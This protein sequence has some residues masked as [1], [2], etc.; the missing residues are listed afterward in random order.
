MP[1]ATLG[2]WTLAW[3]TAGGSDA[4]LPMEPTTPPAS[5]QSDELTPSVLLD[6]IDATARAKQVRMERLRRQLQQLGEASRRVAPAHE[7]PTV[8]ETL[9]SDAQLPEE[10][11]TPEAH[12]VADPP[13]AGDG[14][15][16][17][18]PADIDAPPLESGT[19][20]HAHPEEHG[21][22]ASPP[23]N[24]HAP[25]AAAEAEVLPGAQIDRLAL[26]DSLFATG[27]SDLALQ[28]Y[29]SIELMKL[30]AADRY[31]IEYQIA[32]CHRRLGNKP[33]AEQR[34]RRIAG[35]IDGGWCATHARWWLDAL[36]KKA[37]LERDLEQIKLTLQATEEQLNAK[38]AQ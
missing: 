9:E 34:Y 3:A 14:L 29:D 33:E 25:H 17:P 11:P 22:E 24:P 21:T 30:A 16:V 36:A 1:I 15:A 2:V 8:P 31:W 19:D 37:D 26:A 18:P 13:V 20:E 38:S 6:D 28:A 7:P 23:A 27:Q 5:T 32:N 4:P 10:H 12:E 35:L